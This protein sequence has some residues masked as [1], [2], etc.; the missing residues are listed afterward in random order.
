MTTQTASYY[1]IHNYENLPLHILQA[2]STLCIKFN[3]GKNVYVRVTPLTKEYFL[4][5]KTRFVAIINPSQ[6]DLTYLTLLGVKFKLA[7]QSRIIELYNTIVATGIYRVT[8]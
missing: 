7:A 5:G 4:P 8:I 3:F 1:S 2:K 6:E